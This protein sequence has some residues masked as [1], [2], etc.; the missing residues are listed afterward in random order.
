MRKQGELEKVR[1][2]TRREGRDEA[3]GGAIVLCCRG[4]PPRWGGEFAVVGPRARRGGGGE[5]SV[6]GRRICLG[7]WLVSLWF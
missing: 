4:S 5:T 3:N 1:T 7:V 6:G 2:G